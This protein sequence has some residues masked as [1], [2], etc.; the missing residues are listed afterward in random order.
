[1]RRLSHYLT[2]PSRK[3]ETDEAAGPLDLRHNSFSELDPDEWLVVENRTATD[4][5]INRDRTAVEGLRI[6]VDV[7]SE[8]VRI[9]ANDIAQF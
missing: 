3:Q 7:N 9:S 4:Q 8:T 2:I 1:M 6:A 5:N